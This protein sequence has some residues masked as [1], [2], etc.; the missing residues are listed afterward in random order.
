MKSSPPKNLMAAEVSAFLDRLRAL[1]PDIALFVVD[2][3]LRLS[4]KI[5]PML[6]AEIERR[7]GHAPDS[8]LRIGHDL[9]LLKP[10]L[11]AVNGRRDLMVNIGR[12]LA[13]SLLARAPNP[14]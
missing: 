5:L 10:N 1:R 2:T 4:D 7:R 9:W 13:H 11:Y 6:S 3:A 8:P 12:A 14:L